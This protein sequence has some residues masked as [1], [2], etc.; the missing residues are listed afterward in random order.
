MQL[1][2]FLFLFLIL[3]CQPTPEQEL[4]INEASDIAFANQEDGTTPQPAPSCYVQTYRPQPDLINRK[5]DILLVTDTSRSIEP[6]RAKIAEGLKTFVEFL[7]VNADYRVAQLLAVTGKNSG[8]LFEMELD[9]KGSRHQSY[10]HKFKDKYKK[11]KPPKKYVLRSDELTI[12]EIQQ[13]LED[14]IEDTYRQGF[15]QSGE[16]GLYSLQ[17]ALKPSN[18]AK[19]KSQGFFRDDAALMVVFISDENDICAQYPVGVTPASD[20]F[21]LEQK[22]KQKYCSNVTAQNIYSNL[23]NLKQDKPL[24]VGGV[25]YDENS[26]LPTKAI[27]FKHEHWKKHLN[28]QNE[29]GYGYLDL[30][31]LANGINIQLDSGEYGDGLTRLGRLATTTEIASNSFQLTSNKVDGTTITVEVDDAAQNF[32]YDQGLQ[33]VTLDEPRDNLSIAVVEYCDDIIAPT[34]ETLLTDDIITGNAF[35]SFEAFVYDNSPVITQIYV[36]SVLVGETSGNNPEFQVELQ[37]GINIIELIATDYAGNI[38]NT[39]RL[40]NIVL[41]TTPPVLSISIPDSNVVRTLSFEV[42]GFSNEALQN[43][44]VNNTPL[45]LENNK[46]YFAGIYDAMMEG[47]TTLNFVAED[48]LGNIGSTTLDVTVLIELIRRELI[49]IAPNNEGKLEVTGMPGSVYPNADVNLDGGVFNAI[50]VRSNADGSFSASLDY[51]TSLIISM[52]IIELNRSQQ[53]TLTYNVDTTLSGMVKD[54]YDMPLPGVTVT[55]QASGQTTLTNESGVFSIPNPITG[56]Q[57]ILIDGAT[58]SPLVTGPSKKYSSQI[59]SVSIGTL[60]TNVLERTIYMSPLLTDGSETTFTANQGAAVTSV[61]APGVV[62]TIPQNAISGS[63]PISI[64]MLEIPSDRTSVEMPEFAVP[65][66]VIA[67]EP[68]GLTFSTPVHLELPNYNELPNGVEMVILSKNSKTGN[69]EIDGAATVQ[70]DS[71]VTKPGMGISHFSEVMS[72]PLG[73]KVSEYKSGDRPGADVFNGAVSNSIALPSYKSL[74]QDISPSLIYN[75]R[76]ADPNVVVSNVID[77]PK[78]EVQRVG[79]GPGGSG[80]GGLFKATSKINVTSWITPEW[81]DAQFISGD[82]QSEK[83]RFTGVPNKS[84]ISYAMDLKDFE[85]G[86]H[87]YNSHYDIQLK[88]MTVGTVKIKTKKVFRTKTKTKNI[89]QQ[90]LLDEIFPQDLVGNINLQNKKISNAGTGW[91]IGGVQKIL[92]PQAERILVE[93]DDGSTASYSIDNKIDTLIFNPEGIQ[94]VD[95]NQYP[96]IYYSNNNDEVFNF[97]NGNPLHFQTLAPLT[98]LGAINIGWRISFSF[99]DNIVYRCQKYSYPYT[100]MHNSKKF[101]ID[102][103]LVFSTSTNSIILKNNEIIAGKTKATPVIKVYSN[104]YSQTAPNYQTQC[105]NLFETNCDPVN[106]ILNR[107]AS[108]IFTFISGA[109]RICENAYG[110]LASSGQIFDPGFIDG[111]LVTSKLNKPLDIIAGENN[112]IVISD[113][114]NNRV[115]KINLDD[116]TITTIAGNGQT[117]DNGDGGQAIAASLFHPR[118]LAYDTVGNLYVTTEAGYIRKI[119]PNGFITTFAGKTAGQGGILADSTLAQDLL[120]NKPTGMIYD[121]ELEALYVADTGH[122]R[123]LRIDFET[124]MAETVAGSGECTQGEIGDNK[125]ALTAS[126]CAPEFIGLDPARN[127]LI[128]DTGHNRIRRVIFNNAQDTALAYAPTVKDNSQLLK[129]VD[130]TFIRTYRN[131]SIALFDNQGRQIMQ[132]DRTGRVISFDYDSNGKLITVTDPVGRQIQYEYNGNH[133]L[134]SV[135]DPANRITSF[136]YQGSLLTHVN[137][138]DGSRREFEY[139]IH[140]NMTAETDQRDNRTEYLYNEWRRM[141]GVKKVDNSVIE[142]TDSASELIANDSTVTNP[143]PLKSFNDETLVDGIKDAKGNKTKFNSD[144][145][146][147]IQKITDADNR[148]TEVERNLDGLPTKIIRPDLSFTTFIYDPETNDLLSQFD[149]SSGIT[150]SQAFDAFG[151][152]LE[153]AD[154]RGYKSKNFYNA[155]GLVSSQQNAKNHTTQRNYH[156][157]GLIKEMIMPLGQTSKFEYDQFGNLSKR[158]NA[159]GDVTEY[160]RDLAGNITQTKNAKNEITH[161]EYDNFNRLSAVVTPMGNRTEY[162]YLATGELSLIRDPESNLTRFYY[163]NLGKLIRK[164]D[165][166]GREVKLTYDVNGNLIQ[167][168]DPANQS[169]TFEYDKL[170]QLIKKTLPD[171]TYNLVYDVRGNLELINNQESEIEFDYTIVNGES[172]VSST[173]FNG[174]GAHANLPAYTNSYTYDAIGNRKTLASVAGVT[175]YNYDEIN[176]LTSL[177]NHKSENFTFV[178]DNNSRLT[179]MTRPG[180]SSSFSFDNSNFLTQ[181]IHAGTSGNLTFFEYTRDAIGNRTQMRKPSGSF[182]YDYDADGQLTAA[183]NPEASIPAYANEAFNYDKLGNRTQDTNGLYLYD[184]KKIEIQEDYKYI[185]A[186][187]ANGNLISKQE[188]GF[189]GNFTNYTYSSENQL[190]K[191][192]VFELNNLV[193]DIEYTYDALGRRVEKKVN[194]TFIRRYAY[195]GQEIIAEYNGNNQI[196]AKFTHSSLRTDD[197]LAVDITNDGVTEQL[198]SQS[199][200]YNY[201]KDGLGSITSIQRGSSIV[202]NYSYS[203]YGKL[204][205]I[206]DNF[207]ND[208]TS[209]PVLSTSYTYTNREYDEESSLYYYRARYYSADT[210]RFLQVDPVAGNITTP[211]TFSSRYSYALNNPILFSDPSGRFAFIPLLIVIGKIALSG[212]ITGAVLG[213][214]VG[215]VSSNGDISK[216]LKTGFQGAVLGAGASLGVAG[217]AYIAGAAQMSA[218]GTALFKIVGSGIGAGLVGPSVGIKFRTAFGAGVVGQTLGEALDAIS[219]FMVGTAEAPTTNGNNLETCW[220]IELQD[221][222]LKYIPNIKT[223]NGPTIQN[224]PPLSY[225]IH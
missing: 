221:P 156:A 158:I 146:G 192:E 93:E 190:I 16:M 128:Q 217:A 139:D 193:K 173:S 198:A 186:H 37:E 22:V 214:T 187:D 204:L 138:P 177:A 102:N 178:Y 165:P 188:K 17:E 215:L 174:K 48:L 63:E 70:G 164:V 55:I 136:T 33:I 75:S 112:T 91:K 38:S 122:N 224:S 61:H 72:V 137:F 210:G 19:I 18:I 129:N 123:V 59:I 142:I 81:I 218:F 199:G 185:Y 206:D 211:S 58:I 8:Q 32:T 127:L 213:F 108:D 69:W 131:G 180:G 52:E 31:R 219:E 53:V 11:N 153:Q 205:R 148:V 113:T 49:S 45:T 100:K 20:P 162:E 40:P 7:P 56:D 212:A 203:S 133:L 76:W 54:I 196:L 57:E 89:N 10:W 105:L 46:I 170:N 24:V 110:S 225:P 114:G 207:G 36:N 121:S 184:P 35:F 171:N 97:N 73:L 201:L 78:M 30:I 95:L 183:S 107:T 84:V 150:T 43:V 85:S 74:G 155:Q 119:D 103:G 101:L 191:I 163:D 220:D 209:N 116:Q 160:T 9:T 94:G 66:T 62:L 115:R 117:F 134:R 197:V 172:I 208:I 67:L 176:R 132:S 169:K 189:T 202:Q 14:S 125:P 4:E 104:A 167:E 130:G 71:V 145:T 200:S 124:M 96:D 126:L 82:F 92:N 42:R 151:N 2:Y 65:Q 135:T 168:I 60:Q 12:D 13:Y 68:S 182:N 80:L 161:Y 147:Y 29:I 77:I 87:P 195:D 157:L 88:Q 3:A 175:N 111:P 41:D 51:F 21:K 90:V 5:I 106:T 149:S 179:N 34:L 99:F 6:E 159:S 23:Q 109:E 1:R 152:M 98:G 144:E 44:S 28:A 140:G 181:I 26:T 86:I 194:D 27:K 143:V 39:L 50:T 83:M 79:P 222:K 120:L 223:Y 15:F 166:K 154:A 141:I 216:A 118:G 47:D 64:N 25:L